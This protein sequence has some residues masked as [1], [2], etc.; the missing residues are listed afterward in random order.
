MFGVLGVF[1]V[2]A[3]LLLTLLGALPA[4]GPRPTTPTA[5]ATTA[6]PAAA[7]TA[8]HH[9]SSAHAADASATLCT[10]PVGPRPAPGGERTPPAHLPT[11][12]DK[13][14]PPL[15]RREPA[16]SPA[17]PHCADSAPAD[18]GRAPPA[19]HGT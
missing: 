14:T 3:A 16:P 2:L 11:A 12:Y 4:D 7:P 15:V 19:P 9:D 18:R 1:A 5:P 8:E 10:A 6:A 13:K 17:A